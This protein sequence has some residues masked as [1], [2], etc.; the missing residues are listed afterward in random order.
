MQKETAAH[1]RWAVQHLRDVF[2]EYDLSTIDVTLVTDRDLALVGALD[3]TFP[4]ANMLLC[5]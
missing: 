3:E 4:T 2:E 1:Y 5:R